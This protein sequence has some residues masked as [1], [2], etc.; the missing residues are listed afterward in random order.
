[1]FVGDN[2][3]DQP[4]IGPPFRAEHGKFSIYEGGIRVPLIVAGAGVT[5][6]GEHEDA[7]IAGV[8]IPATVAT[9]AGATDARFHDGRSFQDALTDVSFGGRDYLYMDAIRAEPFDGGRPGWA[10]RDK[11]WKLIEY[12]DGGRELYDMRTDIGELHNL[13]A[14]GIP[15]DLESVYGA[16]EK[17]GKGLRAS[18]PDR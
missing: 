4:V 2:G 5:R 15:A 9:L 6:H 16:L 12:D 11:D 17:A 1:M 10:V 3:T 8:D 14:Q 7:L 18:A 13:I